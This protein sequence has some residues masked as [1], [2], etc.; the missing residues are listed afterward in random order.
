MILDIKIINNK[1]DITFSVDIRTKDVKYVYLDVYENHKNYLSNDDAKHTY[2][3]EKS[4]IFVDQDL[5]QS[6]YKINKDLLIPGKTISGLY[7]LSIIYDDNSIEHGIAYDLNELYCI[8]M[9]YITKCCNN[10]KDT[11]NYKNLTVLMFKEMLLRNSIS[12]NLVDDS[13]AYY[14]E[15]F[16][17]FCKGFSSIKQCTNAV[18]STNTC[19]N[20]LCKIDTCKSGTCKKC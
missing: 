5:M 3:F 6:N 19:K 18:C 7:I 12:L 10:C 17:P 11:A 14:T 16:R 1:S 2:K 4:T 8:R 13:I 15:I 20:N 9:R